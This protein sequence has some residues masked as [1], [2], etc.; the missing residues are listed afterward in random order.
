MAIAVRAEVE[1][2]GADRAAPWARRASRC[3]A[4]GAGQQHPALGAASPA[5]CGARL[6]TPRPEAELHTMAI[7]VCADAEGR[8][9][10]GRAPAVGCLACCRAW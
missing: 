3:R 5:R 9:A 2:H 8:R 6:A 7:A 1:G 10:V 4:M